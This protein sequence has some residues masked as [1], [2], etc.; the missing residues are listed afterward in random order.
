MHG[1]GAMSSY[2]NNDPVIPQLVIIEGKK[3]SPFNS[4]SLD[5]EDQEHQRPSSLYN[6][7]PDWSEVLYKIEDRKDIA[8]NLVTFGHSHC[9]NVITKRESNRQE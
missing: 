1:F 6:E 3:E 9:K 2:N 5:G 7:A 8:D 4:K